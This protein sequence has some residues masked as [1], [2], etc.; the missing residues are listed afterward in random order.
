MNYENARFVVGMQN[1]EWAQ[2]VTGYI[3]INAVQKYYLDLMVI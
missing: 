3:V 2:L 1:I